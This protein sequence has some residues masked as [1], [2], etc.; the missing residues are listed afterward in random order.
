MMKS[1]PQRSANYL[2]SNS[3]LRQQQRRPL[4]FRR[5]EVRPCPVSAP[6]R[7]SVDLTQILER[8]AEQ[9]IAAGAG[10]IFNDVMSGARVTANQ[11]SAGGK[12]NAP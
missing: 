12:R 6:L 5:P 11:G 3:K 9:L 2:A 10:K 7:P 8:Q 1:S 4:G